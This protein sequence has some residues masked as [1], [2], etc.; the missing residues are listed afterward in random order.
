MRKQKTFTGSSR[1]DAEQKAKAW[2]SEKGKGIEALSV[3]TSLL[4]TTPRYHQKIQEPK[5]EAVVKY[6]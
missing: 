1:E 3:K 6:K 5:W 4:F 2:I